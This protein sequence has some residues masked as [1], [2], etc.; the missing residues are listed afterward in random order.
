MFRYR[1]F[2]KKGSFSCLIDILSSLNEFTL[3]EPFIWNQLYLYPPFIYLSTSYLVSS[4][5]FPPC[6]Y[7]STSNL[8]SSY[9]LPPFI[10]LST[11][12]LLSSYLLPPFIYISSSYL[13][14]SYLLPPCIYLL[15]LF[16]CLVIYFLRLSIYL[17]LI[18]V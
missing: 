12:Y 5:L 8:M 6:I 4:Y 10:Y 7:I 17:I 16:W 14:S 9:L 15:L 13:V 1:G 18:G 3:K 11:S 2:P